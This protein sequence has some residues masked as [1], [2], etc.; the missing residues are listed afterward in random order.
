MFFSHW[1]FI[2]FISVY[3]EQ[4][5]IEWKLTQYQICCDSNV[6]KIGNNKY[7]YWKYLRS[8]VQIVH[9][10]IS[11]PPNPQTPLN[12]FCLNYTLFF[13]TVVDITFS[14]LFWKKFQH[15]LDVTEFS[16]TCATNIVFRCCDQSCDKSLHFMVESSHLLPFSWLDSLPRITLL[17]LLGTHIKFEFYWL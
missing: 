7:N 4:S 1:I 13:I 8:C 6:I 2:L 17:S 12:L 14:I 9:I 3:I 16:D 5:N 10:Q 15:P 11:L